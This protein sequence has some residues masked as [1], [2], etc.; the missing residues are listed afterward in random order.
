[1]ALTKDA[2]LQMQDIETKEITIPETVPSWGGE[3]VFIRQLSRGEQDAYLKRQFGDT[4]M[5]QNQA[6]QEQEMSS[7][8]LYGHDA[9]LFTRGV[10]NEDGLRI[11]SNSDE[12]A[13]NEKSGEF[14]GY[15]A[16]EILKFSNMVDDAKTA[17]DF[18]ESELKN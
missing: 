11:F 17:K 6:S 12:K 9:W 15:I 1:M 18:G 7:F 5:K 4:R 16:S 13:V 3:T 2:I 10:C 14:V 8:N